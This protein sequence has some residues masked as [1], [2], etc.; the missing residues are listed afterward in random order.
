MNTQ[1]ELGQVHWQRDFDAAL[2][3]AKKEN[4]PVFLL[5]QE[6]PGCATCTGFGK[7]VL[8]NSLLVAAI[9]HSAVPVVVRNNVAGK[10]A[11]ILNRYSEPAWNNPVVRFLGADG[12]DLIPRDDG[13]YDAFGIASRFIEALQAAKLPVPG[14]LQIAHDESYPKRE[15]AVFTMHCFWEG[16]AALGALPGVVA[17]RAAF[18]NGAEVVEVSYVPTGTTKQA[19]SAAAEKS[20]CHP[21][22][23]ASVREAPPADQ[24]HALRGTPYEKL[25]LTP[26]QR[27]KV[28]SAL[29]LGQD[30]MHW[31]TPAQRSRVK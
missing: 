3:Q 27:T 21:V 6:I 1:P 18:A 16:E 14:Y 28:H 31:L 7:D 2:A 13:V 25:D 11:E 4:K 9:E 24:Q 19:L 23:A 17:T 15:T 29:T 5:F 8:G 12:K 10:E 20:D 30:P 26:M 22:A